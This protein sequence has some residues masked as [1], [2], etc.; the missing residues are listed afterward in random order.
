MNATNNYDL[1]D[2]SMPRNWSTLKNPYM[3][4]F[5]FKLLDV[6]C[7]L[8]SAGVRHRQLVKSGND[9][10]RQDAVMQQFFSLINDLLAQSME[11]RKRCL[12]IVTYKVTPLFP[13]TL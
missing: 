13:V 11:T 1:R 4:R 6:G 3:R 12:N 2:W 9:D 10:L 8:C 7:G 5:I